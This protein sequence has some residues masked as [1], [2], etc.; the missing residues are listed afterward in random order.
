MRVDAGTG[1]TVQGCYN[2]APPNAE[3]EKDKA[4]ILQQVKELDIS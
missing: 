4:S 2:E 1:L 3:N